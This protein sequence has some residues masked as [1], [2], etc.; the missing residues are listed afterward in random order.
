MGWLCRDLEDENVVG[1]YGGWISKPE[2][3]L[4]VYGIVYPFICGKAMQSYPPLN[5]PYQSMLAMM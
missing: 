5:I 3:M 1:S 2:S 4:H